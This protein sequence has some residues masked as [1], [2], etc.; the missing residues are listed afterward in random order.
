MWPMSDEVKRNNLLIY[1][2][3]TRADGPAMTW[4]MHS[5]GFIELGDFDKA[6]QL[7]RRSYETYVRS[8]F[9]VRDPIMIFFV[10]YSS[11]FDILGMD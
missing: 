4:S 5:I 6:E 1:E 7:F 9:N 10:L 11:Y 2:P 3:L 8:P